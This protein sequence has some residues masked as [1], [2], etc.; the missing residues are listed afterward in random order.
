MYKLTK[1]TLV[2]TATFFLQTTSIHAGLLTPGNTYEIKVNTSTVW[3]P[4]G[5]CFYA[6]NCD[7]Q[8]TYPIED[9]N[10]T[11]R[12]FGSGIANDGYAGIITI[13]ADSVGDGFTVNSFNLDSVD[14]T[15]AGLIAFFADNTSNMTGSLDA[16]GNMTFT[17]NGL[18]SAW[19]FFPTFGEQPWNLDP[20]T[21]LQD[22]WTTGQA[23]ATDPATGDPLFFL[24][25]VPI[26]GS[27][28]TGYTGQLVTAGNM[29]SEWDVFKNTPYSARYNISIM[30]TTVVPI[31]AAFWLFGSGLISFIAVARRRYKPIP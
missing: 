19:E 5:S 27:D 10:L 23:S 12:G 8:F 3:S 7:E 25:G 1:A 16:A 11:V 20:T 26:T 6:G 17:P 9:N 28:A 21:G 30:N 15:F 22:V 24:N 2:A 31:P 4:G 18:M 13:T 14:Y 29:G